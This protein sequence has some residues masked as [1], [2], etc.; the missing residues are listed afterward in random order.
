VTPGVPESQ[1]AGMKIA[2]AESDVPA[3]ERLNRRAGRR[4]PCSK[5]RYR[6]ESEAMS[7]AKRLR[8]YGHV[9]QR[10][11]RCSKKNCSAWHLTTQPERDSFSLG[12]FPAVAAWR[13]QGCV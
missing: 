3:F 7:A 2:S 9:D 1:S 13:G 4:T 5:K 10:A 12:K 8:R 6:S 11:Y